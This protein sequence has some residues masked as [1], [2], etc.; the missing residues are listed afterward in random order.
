[1]HILVHRHRSPHS[2][3]PPRCACNSLSVE[4][5]A[6]VREIRYQVRGNEGRR[7]P[8]TVFRLAVAAAPAPAPVPM[9][10]TAVAAVDQSSPVHAQFDDGAVASACPAFS[11]EDFQLR[12]SKTSTP[13]A[14][15][16]CARPRN[17]EKSRRRVLRRWCTRALP[18]A[19]DAGTVAILTKLSADGVGRQ[20]PCSYSYERMWQRWAVN[21]LSERTASSAFAVPLERLLD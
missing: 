14:E 15:D 7:L 18:I 10:S 3:K 19:R 4:V 21:V 2:A 9:V 8:R 1:M 17:L 5:D 11:R 13:P 6:V 16:L 20:G 12:G